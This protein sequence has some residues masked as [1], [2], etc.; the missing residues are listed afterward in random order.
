MSRRDNMPVVPE[1]RYAGS[2]GGTACRFRYKGEFYVYL[3]FSIT[4]SLRILKKVFF[5]IINF[6][7]F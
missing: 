7:F 3:N 6:K 5:F 4:P 2:P 1:G